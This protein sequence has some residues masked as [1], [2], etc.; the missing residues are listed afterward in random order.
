MDSGTVTGRKWF[1]QLMKADGSEMD[2]T[3]VTKW[4]MEST[5]GHLKSVKQTLCCVFCWKG[6]GTNKRASEKNRHITE[7]CP[8]VH[9]LDRL[10]SKALLLPIIIWKAEICVGN[11][12]QSA[13][14]ESIQ[15]EL[16]M[17][18]IKLEKRVVALEL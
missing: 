9:T 12:R 4:L 10:R 1:L 16:E 6:A 2:L 13:T 8:W 11:K 5:S 18:I 7:S 15:R 17:V 3:K 14:A